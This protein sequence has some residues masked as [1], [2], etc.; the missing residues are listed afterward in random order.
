MPPWF[1]ASPEP[2]PRLRTDRGGWAEATLGSSDKKPLSPLVTAGVAFPLWQRARQPLSRTAPYIRS[3]LR[4]KYKPRGIRGRLTQRSDSPQLSNNEVKPNL[5][6]FTR[7]SF[8]IKSNI[9][10]CSLGAQEPIQ[11]SW[12]GKHHLH[13][14]ICKREPQRGAC[15]ESPPG[16]NQCFSLVSMVK[17]LSFAISSRS[18]TIRLLFSFTAGSVNFLFAHWK[19]NFNTYPGECGYL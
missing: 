16:T 12:I 3:G 8:C 5:K 18:D 1:P 17:Y 19:S 10:F 9:R 15:S 14:C 7:G 11:Y 6:Q 4:I 2:S 13:V